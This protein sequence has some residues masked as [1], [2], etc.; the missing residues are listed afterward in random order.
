MWKCLLQVLVFFE[1]SVF[2]LA[3]KVIEQLAGPPGAAQDY[4]TISLWKSAVQID[5]WD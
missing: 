1:M 5:L 2:I 4:F 3:L